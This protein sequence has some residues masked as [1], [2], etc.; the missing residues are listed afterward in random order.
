MTPVPAPFSRLL[1]AGALILALAGGCDDNGGRLVVRDQ[2]GLRVG[3]DLNLFVVTTDFQTGSSSLVR[4]NGEV[5]RDVEPVSPDAVARG[6]GREIYVVNRFGFDNLQIL[7]AETLET[8]RQFSTGNGSNPQDVFVIGDDAFAALYEP[9][10]I[11]GQEVNG[12]GI[13]DRRDGRL[14]GSIDLRPF[15]ENPDRRP[16]VGRILEVNGVLLFLL[17]DL[18]RNFRVEHVGKV[19]FYDPVAREIVDADP[20][21]AET[22]A[23]R[24]AIRNPTA[25]VIFEH[26]G[27]HL[28]AISGAGSSFPQEL[29]GGIEVID[30]ST[31][32]STGTVIED[33]KFGGNIFDI[34]MIRSDLGYAVVQGSQSENF[35]QLLATFDPIAGQVVDREVYRSGGGFLPDIA[36]TGDGRLAI[37]ERDRERPGVVFL[38]IES[39]V[40]APALDVSLPPFSFVVI[41]RGVAVNPIPKPADPTPTP[42]PTGANSTPTPNDDPCVVPPPLAGDLFADRVVL[43]LQ[44]TGGGFGSQQNVLGSPRGQ[45]TSQGSS[46][47]LSLGNGGSIVLEMTD[48]LIVDGSGADFIVYENPFYVGD[49]PNDRFIE[50]GVVSVSQDGITFLRFESRIDSSRALGDPARYQHIAGVEPVLP[51]DGPDCIGGDRFDLAEVGLPSARFVRIEDPGV[52]IDD[53]GNQ[54]PCTN[55]CGF[56]LDALGI[57][58]HAPAP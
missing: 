14:L 31:M 38:D 47:V 7:D 23:L 17:Q 57:L 18:D 40:P 45:G 42:T 10:T 12:I 25:A 16:R 55:N 13:F 19:V 1:P 26:E 30:P 44:G 52:T 56:D 15:A 11:D 50:A 54:A 51:G 3:P 24:L 35:P 32:T 37:A 49:D 36:A 22:D 41:D 43:F 5:E 39:G 58:H 8:D 33:E 6:F 48:N 53:P 4:G 28:V 27:R 9:T 21:T 20:S 29:T 2:S 46:H 34:E